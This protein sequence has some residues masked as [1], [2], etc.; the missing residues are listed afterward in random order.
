MNVK[1][2]SILPS[3]F[4]FLLGSCQPFETGIVAQSITMTADPVT[5]TTSQNLKMVATVVFAG[6]AGSP[7]LFSVRFL[8]G[9]ETLAE[10]VVS[11]IRTVTKDIPVTKSMNGT[12]T[13]KARVFRN[14]STDTSSI[15]SQSVLVT[16]NIP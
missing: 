9:T 3:I 15:D 16:V 14:N 13:I 5:I 8:N 12:L 1:F 10:G 4:I 6:Q 2:L 7:Q 11:G